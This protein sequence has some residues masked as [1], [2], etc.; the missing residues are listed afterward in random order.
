M[1][2]DPPPHPTQ[3]YTDLT[4]ADAIS[5]Y[6][7]EVQLSRSKKTAKAYQFGLNHFTATL[8]DAG[9]DPDRDAPRVISEDLVRRFIEH[10]QRRELSPSTQ[11]L[12]TT[13]LKGFLQYLNWEDLADVDMSHVARYA[14]ARVAKKGYRI[15]QFPKEN[16]E[17]V[18]RY[19]VSLDQKPVENEKERRMNLRDRALI[20]TLVDTGLRV[21]EACQL[22][23]G[24][25][26][27]NEGRAMITGKGDKQAVVRFSQRAL[28]AL[29][30][31][32][33]SRGRLDSSSGRRLSSLPVFIGHDNRGEARLSPMTTKTG[34]T[35]VRQRVRE[36]LGDK[37]VG[38]ITPHTFRH[39]F[40]T[41]VLRATGGNI[42]LAQRLA[43]HSD[44]SITERYAHL[45]DDEL[46]RTYHEVFNQN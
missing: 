14:R 36:S 23:R 12:Y 18:I 43:R 35:I 33:N 30:D 24:D 4:I 31:Y 37:A 41:M 21:H 1:K 16:I 25:L 29:K 6:L 19:A 28:A 7:Q 42:H 13:G 2:A 8:E 38:T 17:R 11:Q 27:W 34:R 39:Y 44:I 26:D 10:L 20:L 5:S 32:L 15:P 3:G 45:S 9:M 40:V 22:R 46:D